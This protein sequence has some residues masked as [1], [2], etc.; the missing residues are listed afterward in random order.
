MQKKRVFISSVQSEFAEERQ[1]LFDYLTTDALLGKFFEPIVFENIP[2]LTVA[3]ET[4]F[5]QEV[6]NCDIYL[7][8]FGKIYG[9]EDVKAFR[10]LKKNL[11]VP[12]NFTK[13]S[14]FI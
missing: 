11:I 10:L 8:L 1:M 13:P 14:S 5:L 7:G 6:E 3:P 2:A 4:V 9:Y 12:Q